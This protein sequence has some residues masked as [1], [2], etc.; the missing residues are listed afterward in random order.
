VRISLRILSNYA[1]VFR[2][3]IQNPRSSIG[4]PGNTFSA[5]YLWLG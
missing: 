3:S 2:S 1:Q 4:N 5:V